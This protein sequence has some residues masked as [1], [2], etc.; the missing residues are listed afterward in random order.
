LSSEYRNRYIQNIPILLECPAAIWLNATLAKA[1][2]MSGNAWSGPG[3]AELSLGIGCVVFVNLELWVQPIPLP[4]VADS[5]YVAFYPL[6]LLGILLLPS[7][8]LTWSEWLKTGLDMLMV[9]FIVTLVLWQYWL[10]PLLV[11][12]GQDSV[13]LQVVSLAY[14]VGDLVLFSGLLILLYRQVIGQTS[15]PLLLL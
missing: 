15:M 6:F 9:L 4:S 14:P 8:P 12:I 5:S 13:A 7:R 10:S 3:L 11:F 2:A 1:Q